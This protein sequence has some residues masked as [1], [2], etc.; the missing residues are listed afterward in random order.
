VSPLARR[1]IEQGRVE[2]AGRVTLPPELD[3]QPGDRLLVGLI[4]A[5]LLPAEGLIFG[6]MLGPRD[7]VAFVLIIADSWLGGMLSGQ[8][9]ACARF[10]AAQ[11]AKT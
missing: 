11:K 1:V 9:A 8:R 6:G 2:P 5:I 3:V 4:A 10:P 7:V